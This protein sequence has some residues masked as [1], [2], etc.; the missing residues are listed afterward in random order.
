MAQMLSSNNRT[1]ASRVRRKRE[2]L[3]GDMLSKLAGQGTLSQSMA[4]IGSCEIRAHRRA[5]T[6]KGKSHPRDMM[7]QSR[8]M[9][10]IFVVQRE[11]RAASDAMDAKCDQ[12]L[13]TKNIQF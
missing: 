11:M 5:R 7:Y 4:A 13:S 1:T 3:V 9:R 6:L 2:S 12:R 10:G 8:R